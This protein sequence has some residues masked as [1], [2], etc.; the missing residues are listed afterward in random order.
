MGRKSWV[1]RA[2]AT[3]DWSQAEKKARSD[4]VVENTGTPAELAA[5][6]DAVLAD[7]DLEG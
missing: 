5:K 7:W 3:G 4:A 2:V 6:V 1:D